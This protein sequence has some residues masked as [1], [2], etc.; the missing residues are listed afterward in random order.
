MPILPER[1]D[2]SQA[3]IIKQHPSS[4]EKSNAT[5]TNASDLN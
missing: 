3:Q 4:A 2:G 5:V 1:F